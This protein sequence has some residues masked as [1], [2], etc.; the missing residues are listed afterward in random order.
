[1]V[2]KVKNKCYQIDYHKYGLEGKT[3]KPYVVYSSKHNKKGVEFKTKKE[4]LIFA[5]KRYGRKTC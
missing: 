2:T 1:M 4:A 5:K 3:T